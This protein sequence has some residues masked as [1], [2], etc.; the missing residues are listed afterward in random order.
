MNPPVSTPIHLKESIR[1][2]RTTEAAAMVLDEKR[3][4]LDLQ[5]DRMD[6]PRMLEKESL[7]LLENIATQHHH[8]L[9]PTSLTLHDGPTKDEAKAVRITVRLMLD[10]LGL[11]RDHPPFVTFTI[12]IM[13]TPEN[14]GW[15]IMPVDDTLILVEETQ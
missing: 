13:D 3:M 8:R 7:T 15:W 4:P 12:L 2:V 5:M 14:T 6:A 1:Q 11:H 9:W 10:V